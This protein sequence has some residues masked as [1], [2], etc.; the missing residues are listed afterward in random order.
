M[1]FVALAPLFDAELQVVGIVFGENRAFVFLQPGAAGGIRQHR[2]LD[3]ILVDGLD[4]RVVRNGLHEDR[5]I[6]VPGRG[7]HIYLQCQASVLLQHAV[8]N[9]LNAL[10]P[11]H[12]RVMNVMGLVVE[13][14][15]LVDLADDLAQIGLAI[16]RLAHRLGAEGIEEVVA[17]IF[18]I[19]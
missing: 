10:E 4:Q 19:Q 17:Q 5:A 3:D 2:V 8:M 1:L 14:G 9:V 15:Q 7:S 6:V 13:H 18:V 12:S 11:G 16:G